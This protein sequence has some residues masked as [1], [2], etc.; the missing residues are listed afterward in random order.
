M[1]ADARQTPRALLI[2][3]LL[4]MATVFF[5][6]GSFAE[7]SSHPDTSTGTKATTGQHTEGGE[8]AAQHASEGN[9]PGVTETEYRPLGIN[10]ESTPLIVAAAVISFGLAGLVAFRPGRTVLLLVVF[11][12]SGFVALE[13]VEVVH[14]AN[15]SKTGL[16]VLALIAAVLHAAVAVLALGEVLTEPRTALTAP[17]G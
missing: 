8:S 13:I 7:R 4:A 11:V 5:L 9:T 17:A 14:Q 2:G 12:A 16:L 10:L 3:A 1:A 6:W 15:V